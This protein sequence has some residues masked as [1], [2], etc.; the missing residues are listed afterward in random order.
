MQAAEMWLCK[1]VTYRFLVT[2]ISQYVNQ[3]IRN[4]DSF[5]NNPL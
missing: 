3:E 5:E 2:L 4:S 1:L